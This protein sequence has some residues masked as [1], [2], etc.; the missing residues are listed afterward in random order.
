MPEVVTREWKN[1][2]RRRRVGD[3]VGQRVHD[4][5]WKPIKAGDDKATA[6]RL[7]DL[8]A[9][10]RGLLPAD[11][12]KLADR[13]ETGDLAPDFAYRLSESTQ[14]RLL[15]ELRL[16]SLAT[17]I[18]IAGMPVVGTLLN[19]GTSRPGTS[20]PGT[21]NPGTPNS[22]TTQ[23]GGTSSTAP[24]TSAE[25]SLLKGA[26]SVPW[27]IGS[28]RVFSR[29]VGNAAVF[30]SVS[31]TI[32]FTALTETRASY[33][34]YVGLSKNGV[35]EVEVAVA[36]A[37]FGASA[38]IK[39]SKNNAG[40]QV[41]AFK[42]GTNLF[43][44]ELSLDPMSPVSMEVPLAVV[45]I[46]DIQKEL[47]GL[48]LS[49]KATL[50]VVLTI[51]VVP[52]YAKLATLAKAG[53]KAMAKAIRQSARSFGQSAL[54]LKGI[55]VNA[56]R[57]GRRAW[58]W[59]I[60]KLLQQV[61]KKIAMQ[62]AK[63]FQRLGSAAT[64]A[65]AAGRALGRFAGKALGVAALWIDIQAN[66]D[67]LVAS[68]LRATLEK[69][70]QEML[71]WFRIGYGSMLSDLTTD[72]WRTYFDAVKQDGML[73]EVW[74]VR[75]PRNVEHWLQK[76]V[77]YSD[78]D[79]WLRNHS[80]TSQKTRVRIAE[81]DWFQRLVEAEVAAVF[82]LRPGKSPD[83]EAT[84]QRAYEEARLAGS[85]AAY[86][87]VMQ[88]LIAHMDDAADREG[89]TPDAQWAGVIQLHRFA[90]SEDDFSRQLAYYEHVS[91]GEVDIIPF[92]K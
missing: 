14:E 69:Q 29:R 73:T 39:V 18:A 89:L 61:G 81:D 3:Q 43:D 49:G 19:R 40:Q 90:Y 16:G 62:L 72:W 82:A 59:I 76:G 65:G 88:F 68:T 1:Q 42:L 66:V 70:R 41:F 38:G 83:G 77:D 45:E 6:R 9:V 71:D 79:D 37:I 58:S 35:E 48:K 36:D 64:Q 12:I 15:Q 46:A 63:D 86:Q 84:R 92:V 27:K 60:E 8:R 11:A 67:K 28:R 20:N 24:L 85:T 5:L 31:G 87:D 78:L 57:S 47:R 53:G 10:F 55:I 22:G 13:L 26:A 91:F 51:D 4:L 17:S 33:E 2:R 25:K 74:S 56:V 44:L 7:D 50:N 23:G 21:A 30:G 80:T 75:P 54:K 52:D 32:V 34:A